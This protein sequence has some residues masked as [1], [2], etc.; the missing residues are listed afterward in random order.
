MATIR[1]SCE[2]CGDLE[3]TSSYLRVRVCINDNRGEYSFRCPVCRMT[4]I[5]AAEPRTI[6]LLVAAGVAM[7]TWSL[8]AELDEHPGREAP[9][10]DLDV[11]IEMRKGKGPNP[12]DA[13]AAELQEQ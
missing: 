11:I 10:I 13:A 6:D 7:D 3:L 5:K 9:P 4:V 12:W 1:T 2:E 8:P